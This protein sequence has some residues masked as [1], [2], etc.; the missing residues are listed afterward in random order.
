M[1]REC[2]TY[3]LFWSVN[4]ISYYGVR[5]AKNCH[6]DDLWKTYFTS[7]KFVKSQVNLYGDP[8]II[9]IRKTF[10]NNSLKAKQWE[11][12]VLKRL[13]VL[14]NNKWLNQSNNNSFR[15]Q[16]KSWN[17]GLNKFTCPSLMQA[18]LKISQKKKNI[19]LSEQVKQKLKQS[20]QKRKHLNS[21]IQLK[22]NSTLYEKYITYEDFILDIISVYNECWGI[23]LIISR[24]LN[25]T[26]KG[27]ITALKHQNLTAIV[28]QT[29][30]K[31]YINYHDKFKSYNDYIIK[32]LLL[33]IKKYTPAQIAKV[34]GINMY[35]VTSLLK[36]LQLTP[37]ICKSGPSSA[38]FQQKLITDTFEVMTA[39]YTLENN[40]LPNDLVIKLRNS[41]SHFNEI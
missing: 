10:G 19:K 34:I 17:E 21:W 15:G 14:H 39:T 18:S 41:I 7:S 36:R 37:Y 29:I 33:H 38:A 24:T 13:N 9:Q 23:P 22:A 4:N 35:G 6:P 12:K 1:S 30:C 20:A 3:R 5:Y 32:I 28:D 2:Y 16:D 11:E 26:E 40:P 27:V 31:V 8:D 25:V